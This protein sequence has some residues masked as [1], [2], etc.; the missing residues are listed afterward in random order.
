M[1][2]ERI[3][4]K[5]RKLLA[6]ANDERGNEQ[7]RETAL[8]QAYSLMSK[9]QIDHSQVALNV[10]DKED[11]RGEFRQDGWS[12]P[13]VRGIRSAI[14]KL[15]M[16]SYYYQKIN[17]TRATHTYVGRESNATTAH[18]MAEWIIAGLLREADKRYGHRLTP[19]GRSFGEGVMQTMW[20]RVYAMIAAKEQEM[21][22]SGFDLVLVDV[23]KREE[24]ANALVLADM[25]IK[26]ARKRDS[27][28]DINAYLAGKQHG[29]T[30]N[31]SRQLTSEQDEGV[32]QA[33]ND[34]WMSMKKFGRPDSVKFIGYA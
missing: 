16:C 33:A 21:R 12:I 1:A 14:A 4:E 13:W 22:G 3:L 23:R 32:V 31:L 28:V 24:D 8:R 9:Y 11:P 19:G 29:K 7:E 5:V 17:A 15:F 27:D 20:T 2:E 30:I 34:I 26:Q 10:L 6:L 18:M 25:D